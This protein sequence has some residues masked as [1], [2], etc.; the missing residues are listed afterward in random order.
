MTT[1]RPRTVQ[2]KNTATFHSADQLVEALKVRN[3]EVLKNNLVSFRN[4]ITVTYDERVNVGDARLTLVAAWLDKSSGA[5]ELF[6]IWDSGSNYASLVL[7]SLAHTLALLSSTPGTAGHSS[8]ILRTLFDSTHAPRLNAHLGGG[9]TDIILAVLKVLNAAASIDPRLTFEAVAWTAK[10]LPKLLSHRHRT[11]TS[12][13]L[14]HP[15]IRTGLTTLLLA[16]LPLTLPLDLFSTL[17]KG[18]AQDD[19]VMIKIILEASWEKVWCDV[20]VPKSVKVKV[21]GGLGM[22]IQPLYE[23]TEPDSTESLAPADIA[24]HFLLALCTN[25]GSGICFRSKGWYPRPSGNPFEDSVQS[26]SEDGEDEM[27]K[28]GTSYNPLLS[29]FVRLL[30]PAGDPRQFELAVRILAACPD[31]VAPYF[32]KGGAAHIGLSL[33]PRLSTRWIASVAFLNSVIGADVP[34]ESFYLETSARSTSERVYRAEPPPLGVIVEN[35]APGVLSRTWLTKALLSKS[36]SAASQQSSGGLVQHTTIRLL[37]RCL[38]KLLATLDSFPPEWTT[39]AAEVTDAVRRRMPEVGVVVGIAQEA[40][41]A[42]GQ[43]G[44]RAQEIKHELLAE[45]ALRLLWLYS[46]VLP[47]AMAEVRF[48]IGKLLQETELEVEKEGENRNGMRVMCQIHVLRLL[49]ESDQFVWHAKAPGASHTHMYRLLSLNIRT[50]YPQLREASA[51][52]V[53]RLL[54]SSIL[55]E[56]DTKEAHVWIDALS[57]NPDDAPVFLEF[58][59]DA[60]S[61]CI[62]TPYRYLETGNQLY[63]CSPD[64][65][66]MPSPLLMAV[67]EQLKHKPMGPPAQRVV[68]SFVARLV[69]TML[70]KIEV[71]SAK[72]IVGYMREVFQKESNRNGGVRVVQLLD[73]FLRGLELEASEQ[74]EI[75][76]TSV[77]TRATLVKTMEI[78]VQSEE[79]PKDQAFRDALKLLKSSGGAI[80]VAEMRKLVQN[81]GPWPEDRVLVGE[82]LEEIDMSIF[83]DAVLS[84]DGDLILPFS[85]AFWM[86]LSRNSGLLLNGE[87]LSNSLSQQS[88]QELLWSCGL[89]SHSLAAA[90]RVSSQ[91]ATENCLVALELIARQA[92]GTAQ[93]VE[94]KQR[95][96]GDMEVLRTLMFEPDWTLHIGRL[97]SHLLS[98]KDEADRALATP[99][100]QHWSKRL[101]EAK[102]SKLQECATSFAIWIPFTPSLTCVQVFKSLLTAVEV[103]API[104]PANKDLLENLASHLRSIVLDKSTAKQLAE[105]IPQLVNLHTNSDYRNVLMLAADIAERELPVGLGLSPIER[106]GDLVSITEQARNQWTSR[107]GVLSSISWDKFSG[108]I[109][110][111]ELGQFSAALMY[112]SASARSAFSAWIAEQSNLPARAIGPCFALLDCE[113]AF[114]R[115]QCSQNHLP[116]PTLDLILDCASRILFKHGERTEYHNWAA[117]TLA[118]AMLAF[119]EEAERIVRAVTKRFPS[120]HRDVV[121]THIISLATWAINRSQSWEELA[122][123]IVDSTLLWLVRRFAE[124]ESDSPDLL[125]TFPNFETLLARTPSVKPHLAEPV[126]VAALKNRFNSPA[127]M[128]LCSDLVQHTPLKPAS[129]N[130]LLQSVIHHTSFTTVC[131]TPSPIRDEAIGLLHSLFFKHPS[132]TC[133]P[134]HV[135]PLLGIYHGTLDRS[136]T[137]ILSIFRLF[138]QSRQMSTLAILR[139]WTPEVMDPQP[140]DLLASVCS[141]D[142]V[143]VFRT[144]T[145]FPQRRDPSTAETGSVN[146]RSDIY[147]PNFVL[148]LLAALMVSDESVTSTE[149]VDLCR[150]NVISLAISSLSSK[151]PAMRQLGYASL[152]TGYVRLLDVDFEERGQ[153]MYNL[154][155]LRNLLPTPSATPSDPIPRLPTYTTLL[156]AHAVRDIFIPATP[157]YP[158]LSRFLLQRP[159]YDTADVPMLYTL[160]YSSSAEWKRERGWMLRFL[161]DGMRSTE[162]WRVLKRRHTWDLL[163]DLFQ[164][165]TEERA[166]RLSILEFLTNAS[167]NK[168]AATSLLLRASILSWIHLQLDSVL[169]GEPLAYL[170]VIENIILVVDHEQVEKATSG[171]WRGI[172]AQIIEKIIR[173]HYSDSGLVFLSSRILLRLATT[174]STTPQSFA[175]PARAILISLGLYETTLL[176][177]TLRLDSLTTLELSE[178]HTNRDLLHPIQGTTPDHW[179][180]SI[181]AM[182]RV[183]IGMDC[184]DPEIWQSISTR[185]LLLAANSNFP[186]DVR[187]ARE[188]LVEALVSP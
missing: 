25:P 175:G 69:R 51:A 156:L 21:F 11:P 76:E 110:T 155:L 112:L 186:E 115:L 20:K 71:A 96:F 53:V 70:G 141:F 99:Y 111:P 95:L 16:L 73:S 47:G 61:R 166:L 159:E 80:G 149:W 15:S 97:V 140:K 36:T 65:A 30:R 158:L 29:K 119:P 135:I 19:G 92:V 24:H 172:V 46:L 75:D 144:C 174:L 72:A 180:S 23:R 107:T 87:L 74:M 57:R 167:A 62:K 39:R 147:D 98:S 3:Q 102:G 4:Q 152:A 68:A 165:A 136:D 113:A 185:M 59:D 103:P 181:R 13:P 163:A 63:G 177:S 8:A 94:L 7:V 67:L 182:W 89:V 124:D 40:V 38:L 82:F 157:L 120:H 150:T 34:I 143:L 169:P 48:D 17:F 86:F 160:L 91:I 1:K 122:E 131:R 117:Q 105:I 173:N 171:H 164:S 78:V 28:S 84:L 127:A 22:F 109:D 18:L 162:D 56:H 148:P 130:K 153:L 137:R 12:Q 116:K 83:S 2:T 66:R 104:P 121:Q 33:E 101:L 114:A 58:F 43:E 125:A 134:S 27:T 55:F 188:Q 139:Y 90:V 6:D 41:K 187:W 108:W 170:K 142:P 77:P 31:L 50:P 64:V 52:L 45:G 9:Q 118:N 88:P 93:A 184:V 14:A 81:L 37:T 176:R 178:L 179:G 132:S 168:Y 44:D 85:L 5:S 32:A 100:S 126:L 154:N 145:S 79:S 129:V 123:S 133:H 42:L 128:R 151:Q 35:I 10:A 138:E 161:A 49:G 183:I 26:R 106:R 60:I 146:H 54:S